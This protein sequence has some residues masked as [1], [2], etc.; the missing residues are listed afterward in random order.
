VTHCPCSRRGDRVFAASLS[1]NR[2]DCRGT[3]PRSAPSGSFAKTVNSHGAAHRSRSLYGRWAS[4]TERL[5]CEDREHQ[6]PDWH[7]PIFANNAVVPCLFVRNEDG[8]RRRSWR[9]GIAA[10]SSRAVSKHGS[11]PQR[12]VLGESRYYVED[13]NPLAHHPFPYRDAIGP[14][15]QSV[16]AHSQRLPARCG[17]HTERRSAA[18]LPAH[19]VNRS[20]PGMS[21]DPSMPKPTSLIASLLARYL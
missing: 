4:I 5:A 11:R 18:R 2:T 16:I 20:L 9:H 21:R 13:C 1:A 19:P 3:G 10:R 12:G 8:S 6:L 15:L 14:I 17:C 7:Q